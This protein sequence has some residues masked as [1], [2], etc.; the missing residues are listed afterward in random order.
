VV[1]LHSNSV[2]VP[3]PLLFIQFHLHKSLATCLLCFPLFPQFVKF[4][5]PLLVA[6]ELIHFRMCLGY[7][8]TMSDHSFVVAVEFVSFFTAIKA[9]VLIGPIHGG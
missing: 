9:Q 7:A 4:L 1:V 5:F 3:I 8:D 2:K 6:V